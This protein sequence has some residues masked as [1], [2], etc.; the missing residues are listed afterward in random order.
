MSKMPVIFVGHG[1]PMSAIEKNGFTDAWQSLGQSLPL[2]KAILCI[3]AHWEAKGTSVT[4]SVHPETIH[5]FAGFPKELFAVQYPAAGDPSLAHQI[6]ELLSDIPVTLDEKR[7]LDHGTWSVLVHLYP[8]ANIPVVQLSLDYSLS[9]DQMFKIAQKLRPLREKGVL[10]IGSGNIVHNLRTIAWSKVNEP[11]YAYEWASTANEKVK[12]LIL[13]NDIQSLIHYQKLG[14]DVAHS[15]PTPEH[16]LPLLYIMA[17]KDEAEQ[18]QFFND[19][20]V[21]G[22]LSMTSV[23]FS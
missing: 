3:S 22:S 10:I 13:Q 18:A 21:M 19:K 9:P 23:V 20:I 7:G 5:D 12:Q 4:S 1:S 11:E 8:Q 6:K 16:Y 17:L 14:A 15:V 2:P